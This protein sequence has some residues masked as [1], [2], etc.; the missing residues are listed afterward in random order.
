MTYL[1]C[2][3][4]KNL[5]QYAFIYQQTISKY[6][7]NATFFI[8]F[9]ENNL[10]HILFCFNFIYLQDTFREPPWFFLNASNMIP[11]FLIQF[12]SL[13][14][15][16]TDSFIFWEKK[17]H[18]LT[19]AVIF[20]FPL[21]YLFWCCCSYELHLSKIELNKRGLIDSFCHSRFMTT[22]LPV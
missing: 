4:T 8:I 9:F 15:Y 10:Q 2:T 12:I 14:F 7:S 16:H 6:L 22:F 1:L 20:I 17:K 3:T 13:I 18:F 11:S 21:L 19:M 5:F